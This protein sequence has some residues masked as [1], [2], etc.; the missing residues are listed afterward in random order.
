M[1]EKTKEVAEFNPADLMQGVR[2]KIKA[3]FVSLIPVEHWDQLCQK[4]IDVFFKEGDGYRGNSRD[5]GKMSDF[6][7][8]CFEEFEVLTRTKIKEMLESYTS[9]EWGNNNSKISENL[10]KLIKEHSAEIFTSMLGGMFQTAI[11]NMSTS[12]Y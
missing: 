9:N 4:E 10:E 2:D 7:K 8:I 12:R 5:W 3:T 1:S 6:Q 11:N